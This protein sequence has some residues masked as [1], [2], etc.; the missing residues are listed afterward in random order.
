M[1]NDYEKMAE[2]FYGEKVLWSEILTEISNF[3]KYFNTFD[4]NP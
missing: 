2:M 3:K 1:E 4:G